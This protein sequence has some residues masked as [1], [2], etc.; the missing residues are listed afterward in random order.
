MRDYVKKMHKIEERF[1]R[2]LTRAEKDGMRDY[3]KKMHKIEEK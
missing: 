2:C 3:V 1:L